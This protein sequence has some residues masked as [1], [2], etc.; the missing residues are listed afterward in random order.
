MC[1]CV[2]LSVCLS[3]TRRYCIKTAKRRITQTTPRDSAGTQVSREVKHFGMAIV[4]TRN[5]SL[6]VALTTLVQTTRRT[7]KNTSRCS[8]HP[9]PV[10]EHFSSCAFELD[11]DRA[12]MKQHGS[13]CLDR[14]LLSSEVISVH[15]ID[16]RTNTPCRL[17]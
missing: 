4:V 13:S 16:T 12:K 2:C 15:E 11:L 7:A 5:P 17:F 1:V 14:R 10:K 3:V 9:E 8:V 6:E